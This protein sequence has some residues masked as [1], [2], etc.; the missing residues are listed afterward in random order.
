MASAG[1][2]QQ[3]IWF[4]EEEPNGANNALV[5]LAASTLG[6]TVA[7]LMKDQGMT[8]GTKTYEYSVRALNLWSSASVHNQ[9]TAVQDQLVVVPE[10]TTMIAA[11]MLVL[12]FGVSTVRALR[13]NRTA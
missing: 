11:A 1:A 9:S 4:L 5:Q 10:P 13:K 12:P 8:I 2:L 3:A 7:D 6:L